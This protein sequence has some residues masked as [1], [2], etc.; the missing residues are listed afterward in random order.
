[1]SSDQT[2]AQSSRKDAPSVMLP[3]S[4]NVVLELLRRQTAYNVRGLWRIRGQRRPIEKLALARLLGSGLAERVVINHWLQ[5]RLTQ[6]G[7]SMGPAQTHGAGRER[8][9]KGQP[10]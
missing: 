3:R 7:R 2:S 5:L 6:A 1:M 4:A 8:G 10:G 9:S